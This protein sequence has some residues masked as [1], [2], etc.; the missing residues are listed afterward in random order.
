MVLLPL[1]LLL[2]LPLL[3]PTLAV[4]VKDILPAVGMAVVILVPR[5]L[6]DTLVRPSR[7]RGVSLYLQVSLPTNMF[8]GEGVAVVWPVTVVTDVACP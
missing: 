5:V 3:L 4:M 8:P 1:L 7:V 2:L 6:G